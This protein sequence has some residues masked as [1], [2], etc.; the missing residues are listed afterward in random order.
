MD[1]PIINLRMMNL[2]RIE[3]ASDTNEENDKNAE[4]ISI[5]EMAK[6]VKNKNGKQQTH[7][8]QSNH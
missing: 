5:T 2:D 6:K 7:R 4:R 1:M 8:I 3:T